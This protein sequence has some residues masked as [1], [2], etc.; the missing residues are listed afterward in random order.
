LAIEQLYLNFFMEQLNEQHRIAKKTITKNKWENFKKKIKK[1]LE[2]DEFYQSYSSVNGRVTKLI[3]AKKNYNPFEGQIVQCWSFFFD[4]KIYS[5]EMIEREVTEIRKFLKAC[6]RPLYNVDHD[7]SQIENLLKVGF[8]FK[9]SLLLGKVSDGLKGILKK[10]LELNDGFVFDR[11]SG[12]D[13]SSLLKNEILAHKLEMTSV[14]SYSK[15]AINEM[16]ILMKE[17]IQ[18]NALFV[19]REGRKPIAHIGNFYQDK[20]GHIAVICVAPE[21]QGQGLAYLLYE[22]S[23]RDMKK[24]KCVYYTGFSGTEKVLKMTKI[25]KRKPVSTQL[26]LKSL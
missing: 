18:D 3:L 20:K 16:K 5:P 17:M 26:V 13:I 7:S 1:E 8:Q 12:K 9:G 23:L 22:S 24:R 4:S 14:L 11:A 2:N 21:Y 25:L 6:K 19:I 15:S 10:N